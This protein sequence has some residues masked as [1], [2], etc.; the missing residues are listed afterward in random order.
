MSEPDGIDALAIQG[1]S[2]TTLRD[3]ADAYEAMDNLVK[4]VQLALL[5][6]LT[7]IETNA[8]TPQEREAIQKARQTILHEWPVSHETPPPITSQTPQHHT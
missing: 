1:G 8:H 6:M 3:A 2:R 7:V 5:E 4:A